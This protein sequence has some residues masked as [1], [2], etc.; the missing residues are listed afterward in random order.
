MKGIRSSESVNN[1]PLMMITGGLY[2]P[3]QGQ[4]KQKTTTVQSDSQWV[5]KS[6]W[7]SMVWAPPISNVMIM[8]QFSLFFL[9]ISSSKTKQK[10]VADIFFETTIKNGQSTQLNDSL[11]MI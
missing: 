10:R 1:Q 4:S 11:Y 9:K 6:N 5:Q 3:E 2:T 8:C 7:M